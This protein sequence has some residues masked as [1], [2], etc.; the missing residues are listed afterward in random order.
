GYTYDRWISREEYETLSVT[1]KQQAL[2]Q[3]IVLEDSSLERAEPEY[4][5]VTV[6][7]TETIGDGIERTENGIFVRK[8]G[9]SM[10]LTFTGIPQSE[11]Y[12]IIEGLDFEGVRPSEQYTEEEWERLTVYEQN[13]VKQEDRNWTKAEG[14]EIQK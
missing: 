14:A 8:P 5:D 10:T 4:E 1:E 11:T 6:E 3:G 13:Q 2:L 7:Y 9:A 12:L